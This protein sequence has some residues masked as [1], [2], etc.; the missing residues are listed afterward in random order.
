MSIAVSHRGVAGVGVSR[1]A[2]RGRQASAFWGGRDKR[3]AIPASQ[4][5]AFAWLFGGREFAARAAIW[6]FP[7]EINALFGTPSDLPLSGAFL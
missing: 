2:G 5:L 1:R 7:K 6:S 4:A 3:S